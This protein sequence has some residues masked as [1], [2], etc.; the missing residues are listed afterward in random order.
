V[1]TQTT[2]VR[3]PWVARCAYRPAHARPRRGA[4]GGPGPPDLLV[5]NSFFILATSVVTG[6]GGFL[7]WTL[8]ARL[9][10]AA[11][12]GL[13]SALLGAC[14]TLASCSLLGFNQ[15]L[16]RRL[17]GSR[18]PSRLIN[19]SLVLISGASIAVATGYALIVPS[20]APALGSLHEVPVLL[21][22]VLVTA[23]TGINLATDSVFVAHQRAR[24]NFAIDGLLQ[25]TVKLALPA[26][27]VWLG[28]YG[29]FLSAG[30]ATAAAAAASVVVLVRRF[31]YRPRPEIDAGAVR[32]DLA[33][34]SGTYLAE[35]LDLVPPLVLPL[36]IVRELGPQATAYFLIAFQIANL[37]YAGIFAVSQ[38]TF[39]EGCRRPG[40]LRALAG[41]SA[42][43]LLLA[44]LGGVALAVLGP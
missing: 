42:R 26:A 13:A 36:L 6:A 44:P 35:L 23:L 24:F 22:F 12:V 20:F 21:A 41:R 14:A 34:S 3:R 11:Q 19:T 1:S 31:G 2:P 8:N 29:V 16:V 28:A 18:T 17:P 39:A 25:S 32:R 37:L 10:T 9:F 40:S 4:R 43:M 27:L 5:D 15:T 38:A 30:I 7:F 33:F